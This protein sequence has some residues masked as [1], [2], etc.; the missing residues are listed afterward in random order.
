MSL[1]YVLELATN[2]ELL[3][4]IRK[5]GSFSNECAS[6]YAAQ[7]GDTIKAIHEAGIVH[8]DIK[9]E[10]ILLDSAMRI[11]VTDFGS[12]KITVS[13]QTG[14]DV[15]SKTAPQAPERA[16]SFV[17]TAE[18]VSPE[19]LAEGG[20][21][22]GKPA[23]WWAFGCVV[24]QM[25]A[26]R[27]PF[28]GHNEYQTLQKV[29]NRDFSFPAGFPAEARDLV[30]MI[31]SLDP[32]L[33]PSV[34]TIFSHPYFKNIDFD[35]LWRMPPPPLETGIAEPIRSLARLPS[36]SNTSFDEGFVSE[37]SLEPISSLGS[38]TPRSQD[39]EVT[40]RRRRSNDAD[41]SDLSDGSS[42][43]A[44]DADERPADRPNS[45][46]LKDNI[47]RLTGRPS[48][49]LSA[50]KSPSGSGLSL[51][52]QSRSATPRRRTSALSVDISGTTRT[53]RDQ[54]LDM[55]GG[56][57]SRDNRS[58]LRTSVNMNQAVT[59][60][61]SSSWNAL[62]LPHELMLYSSPVLQKK[63]GTGKMFS[64]RRHLI[65]TDFPRLLCVKE[66]PEALKVKSEVILSLPDD[67]DGTTQIDRQDP[68]SSAIAQPTAF[69]AVHDQPDAAPRAGPNLLTALEYKGGKLFS[70][71]TVSF[72]F[73]FRYSQTSLSRIDV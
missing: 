34:T 53:S 22:A 21:P 27:P 45:V 68:T 41:D 26:G 4:Y 65:V 50:G 23:D 14:Q 9:P 52:G 18:Y 10:N 61:V 47:R 66:T 64:K 36:N 28:K 54:I 5:F 19:L 39:G 48:S 51:F 42:D 32:D 24:F 46:K 17:G 1:D 12:A 58:P 56:R 13:S 2:G 38:I 16:S 73:L 55:T 67:V 59:G 15:S 33:R 72:S 31:L 43:L 7:L 37:Q 6:F 29:K 20:R 62:L 25:V 69:A 40:E 57:A 30:D 60:N 44:S 11:K 63:T 8:R 49:D 70:V 3:G 71:K 35:A